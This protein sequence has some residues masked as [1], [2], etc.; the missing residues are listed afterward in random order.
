MATPVLLPGKFHGLR[1]LVGY[2]LWGRKELDMTEQLHYFFSTFFFIFKKKKPSSNSLQA[3]EIILH[4]EKETKQVC[5]EK[6][7]YNLK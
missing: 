5:V 2:S 1:S 4:I 7:D 3:R 6:K